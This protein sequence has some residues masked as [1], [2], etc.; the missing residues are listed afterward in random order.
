[1]TPGLL[2]RLFGWLFRPAPDALAG[3]V[4]GQARLIVGLGNP[5]EQYA[6][7]RHNVGFQC[8]D[9]LAERLGLGWQNSDGSL[10]AAADDGLVLAKPQTFMNRSGHAVADLVD[11]LAIEGE[12][13]LIIYDDMDLPFGALR[14]RARGGAGTH[15]GMRSVLAELGS[16]QVARLR[17]GI[18]QAAPG[19]AIDHVLSAFTPEEQPRVDDLIQR[20]ADAALVWANEGAEVAMN[21][22]NKS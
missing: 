8:L 18:S 11:R 22:Y 19:A 5:G 14:L 15:N 7:T 2:D 20:A 6:H 13:V 10:V 9:R 1:M 16:E 4:P 12:R 17:I 21:R 3:L